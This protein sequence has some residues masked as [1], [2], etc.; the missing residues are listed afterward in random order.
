MKIEQQYEHNGLR[1]K[2]T[3]ESIDLQTHSKMQS[4]REPLLTV[5]KQD[6]EEACSN[7]AADIENSMKNAPTDKLAR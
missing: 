5:I 6:L 1:L 3:V 2:A 7:L 4:L